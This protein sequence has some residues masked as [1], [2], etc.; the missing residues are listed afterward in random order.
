[1]DNLN[2]RKTRARF[3]MDQWG[4]DKSPSSSLS[5]VL[6]QDTYTYRQVAIATTLQVSKINSTQYK[7]NVRPQINLF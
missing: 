3:Q 6:G 4:G 2:K 7:C 1:M 5:V